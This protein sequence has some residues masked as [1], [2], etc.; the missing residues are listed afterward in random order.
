MRNRLLIFR[1]APVRE[2]APANLVV[3]IH[4]PLSLREEQRA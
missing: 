4:R 3:V 1:R 2:P